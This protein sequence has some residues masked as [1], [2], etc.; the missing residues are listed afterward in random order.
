MAAD[1]L[2]R[3]M[4]HDVRAVLNRPNQIRRGKRRV[5]DQRKAVL[6]RHRSDRLNV[7]DVGVRVAECLN[8]DRLRVRLNRRFKRAVL[9]WVDKRGRYAARLRQRVR[10]QIIGAAVDRFRRHNMLAGLCQRVKRIA[11]RRRAGCRRQCRA[12][13]LQRG[14]ALLK[15]VLGRVRQPSVDVAGVLEREAVCRVLCAVEHIRR[16]CVNRH[17]SRVRRRVCL[18]LSD[19]KLTR[20][21]APRFRVL[22]VRHYKNLLCHCTFLIFC[23]VVALSSAHSVRH[24]RTRLSSTAIGRVLRLSLVITAASVLC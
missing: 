16:R 4:H 13:A 18:F 23:D 17:G 22:N 6:V 5:D 24:I 8:E 11:D 1:E 3:R 10:Q 9:K 2:R 15:N 7:D 20:L 12:A 21:K 14:D 19:M